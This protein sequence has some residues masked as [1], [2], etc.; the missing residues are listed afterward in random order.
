[1]RAPS[2]ERPS[3]SACSRVQ[4]GSSQGLTAA[5][6]ATCPPA[7]LTAFTSASGTFARDSSRAN[8]A[9]VVSGGIWPI[10]PSR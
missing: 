5:S 9:S 1:M 2:S 8:R 10:A 7:R 4:P 6:T 3:R